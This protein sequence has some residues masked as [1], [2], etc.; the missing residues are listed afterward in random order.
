M[1]MKVNWYIIVPVAIA[2]VALVVYLI[3]RNHK[4]EIDYEK[5]ENTIIEDDDSESND[6]A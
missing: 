2:A 5:G 1:E 4:D 6:D 3:I